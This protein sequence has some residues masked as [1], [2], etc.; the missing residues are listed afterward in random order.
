MGYSL[1]IRLIEDTGRVLHKQ[2]QG[3]RDPGYSVRAP[4]S[5]VL[6]LKLFDRKWTQAKPQAL[7]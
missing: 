1:P 2:A 7:V 4:N 5:Y 3:S 6:I